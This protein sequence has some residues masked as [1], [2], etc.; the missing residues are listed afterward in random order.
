MK[1]PPGPPPGQ[2][3]VQDR[4]P[5]QRL[6][7]RSTAETVSP[8][9]QAAKRV[10]LDSASK[11][12]EADLSR[13]ES[14]D[15][16]P[17]PTESPPMM[18][19][20]ARGG[21]APVADSPFPESPVQ[22]PFTPGSAHIPQAFFA[23]GG[24]QLSP[25][26]SSSP[27][28]A[29]A[30]DPYQNLNSAQASSPTYTPSSPQRSPHKSLPSHTAVAY[31]PSATNPG[32]VP[33]AVPPPYLSAYATATSL[34]SPSA[35]PSVPYVPGSFVAGVPFDALPLYHQN[36]ILKAATHC[37]KDQYAEL[38]H[39]NIKLRASLAAAKGEQE[40]MEERLQRLEDRLIRLRSGSGGP[41]V[42][43]NDG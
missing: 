3:G 37:W 1:K 26:H 6:L 24:P 40:S 30:Y 7:K 39:D 21:V 4:S 19:S 35:A 15:D 13:C 42:A 27:P 14:Q 25:R 10:N 17:P 22:G 32:T 31:T 41:D 16:L 11:V 34:P 8:D 29:N 20:P 28:P 18:H 5:K 2:P 23:E 38:Q 43:V 36:F 12:E 9:V 33:H